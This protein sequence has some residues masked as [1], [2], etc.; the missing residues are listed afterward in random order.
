MELYFGGAEAPTWQRRLI[1]NGVWR[2]GINFTHLKNRLP[3]TK[4]WSPPP[5]S[6]LLYASDIEPDFVDFVRTNADAFTR[7]LG[8]PG[9]DPDEWTWY[10]RWVPTWDPD[11]TEAV[12][13]HLCTRYPMVAVPGAALRDQEARY[14][15]RN[16]LARSGTEM[17]VIGAGSEILERLR[18][19]VVV[20]TSWIGP[21]RH[22]ETMIWDG[23]RLR[24]YPAA[25]KDDARR[26]HRTL[27]QRAGVDI[28][29]LMADDKDAAIA[30]S[31]WSWRQAEAAYSPV[32]SS[33]PDPMT[34]TSSNVA[35]L[36]RNVDP[37]PTTP[38]SSGLESGTAKDFHPASSGP[39]EVVADPTRGRQERAQVPL[40]VAGFDVVDYDTEGAPEGAQ[41]AVLSLATDRS[42]RACDS[43]FLSG[44]C[45]GYQPAHVCA[46]SIPIEIRTKD[47]L[48]ATM[49]AMLEMQGQRV[50]FARMVEEL[51]GGPPDPL[52][53]SEMDRMLRMIKEVKEISDN[54]DFVRLEVQAK[55]NAG[56]LSRLFGSHVGDANRELP[57][58]LDQEQTDA[59][60][61]G[62]ID[63]E[64]VTE[65]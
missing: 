64:L 45:P 36:P 20:T 26:R 47:Q 32:T 28:D 27:I 17:A 37:P 50:L 7:V 8:A 58:P 25:Q 54:R 22:G 18:P 65:T 59:L 11:T 35:Y 10:D 1:D 13:E 34:V 3:K 31:L 49:R 38:T 24:R 19:E 6:L 56:V 39:L 51:D 40:P 43:C 23:T 46:Y 15:V 57:R 12:L 14:R 2:L 29:A 60:L 53:S 33:T 4:P 9:D 44:R 48:R 55:G 42:L 41:Q 21:V 30:L 61:G 5:G 16:I 63:A 62:V 52:V